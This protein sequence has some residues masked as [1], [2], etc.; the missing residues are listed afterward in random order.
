MLSINGTESRSGGPSFWKLSSS[1][2]DDKEYVSLKCPL[3][4]DEFKEVND[5]M[6]VDLGSDG[7]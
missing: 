3:W 1:L 4:N 5:P 7:V 6:L 2:L